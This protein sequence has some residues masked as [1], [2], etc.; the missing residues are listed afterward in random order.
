MKETS[1]GKLEIDGENVLY[2]ERNGSYFG[3]TTLSC[4]TF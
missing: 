4:K 3:K 1:T 2:I